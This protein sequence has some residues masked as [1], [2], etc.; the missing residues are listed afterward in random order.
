MY[1]SLNIYKCHHHKAVL[2]SRYWELKIEMAPGSNPPHIAHL[3]STLHNSCQAQ[4][5]CGAGAGGFAV[6]V[7][8]TGHSLSDQIYRL[9]KDQGSGSPELSLHRMKV[10]EE[11]LIVQMF[12][13][14]TFS[15][16]PLPEELLA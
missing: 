13:A 4:A 1:Y 2:V 6:L 5:L 15:E 7:E 3:L 9:I 11:G 14:N 10:D 16:V 12:Q 8:A